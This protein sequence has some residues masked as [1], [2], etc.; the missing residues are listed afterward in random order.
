MAWWREARFGL[1]IHWGLYA[2]PAGTWQGK[3]TGGAEWILNTARI[4]PDDYMPLQKQFNPVDFDAEEWVTIAKNAGMRYIVITSKHHDGFCLW[5]SEFTDFDISETPF[6]RDI[7]GELAEACRRESIVLCFYH[8]I[9]DWTHPDYLPRRQWDDRPTDDAEFDAYVAHMQTQVDELI[10]K[11]QP[12]VL[13]FDGEWEGTWQHPHGQALYDH[14]RT[15]APWVIINNRVDTGRTGMA[16]L[17]RAGGYRGDFGTPEQQIPTT[18]FPRG[19]DWETC[20]TMNRSWGWQSFDDNWKSTE[21]L[22][23]KLVD[24]A[25][26]GGNFLLNVGP[27]GNGEFPPEAV[28]RL[29]TIGKWMDLN[30][31]SVRGTFASPFTE[32]PWGRCTRRALP[33]GNERL[34]LH[35][36][37]PP[38]SGELELPGLMNNPVNGKAHLLA[39]D[40]GKTYDVKRDEASL[41]V[42]LPRTLPDAIDTVLVLDIVGEA[43]VVGP[44]TIEPAPGSVFLD[45]I[46][47]SMSTPSDEIDIRYTL[48]G[49]EPNADSPKY[50]GQIMLGRTTTS[51][52]RCFLG[53]RPVSDTATAMYEKV[54][55]EA[56]REHEDLSTGLLLRIWLG[57]FNEVPDFS[58]RLAENASRNPDSETVVEVVDLSSK[59]RDEHFGMEFKGYISVPETGLYRFAIDSDDGSQLW[60]AGKKL[61]D[62]DG[63]HSA[64]RMEAT[65]AL[66]RGQHAFDVFFFE[67]TGQDELKVEWAYAN[68]PF[69][70]IPPEAYSH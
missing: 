52:A 2:V 46:G 12:A 50:T 27:M 21:D 42:T 34:Y 11:Y 33:D 22:I 31:R 41:I 28:S 39:D 35:V 10:G 23:R 43:I 17:T 26:K 13:W 45:D 29:A 63:L 38:E 53:D 19:V 20:M 30:A 4:H 8:S 14:I 18:G 1:F 55:P 68:E 7:L 25:S 36:F 37:G 64:K 40:D 44:P 62:N 59:P 56:S 3:R 70:A 67:K 47:I 49:S 60:I 5:P 69:T 6:K 16:G 32:L 51:K 57:D 48:D 9:M 15:K 65:I 58:H 61:I 24:I 66:E 54:V